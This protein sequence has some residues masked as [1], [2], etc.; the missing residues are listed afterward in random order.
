[1]FL[2]SPSWAAKRVRRGCSGVPRGVVIR[3]LRK[4]RKASFPGGR[5]LVL[6]DSPKS[7]WPCEPWDVRDFCRACFFRVPSAYLGPIQAPVRPLGQRLAPSV[8]P[9]LRL[10]LADPREGRGAV[11]SQ[12]LVHPPGLAEVGGALDQQAGR[13]GPLRRHTARGP[14]RPRQGTITEK[15]PK[16]VLVAGE[17]Q[18]G[19]RKG[20]AWGKWAQ[21][22]PG[23]PQAPGGCPG[24]S[25]ERKEGN[26]AS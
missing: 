18:R 12:V 7:G 4:D 9:A 3:E 5:G 25:T 22:Y 15:A 13:H 23:L 10:A 20:A 17:P 19:C 6:T 1:M 2:K 14:G 11:G 8:L 24:G 26:S 21:G 16:E